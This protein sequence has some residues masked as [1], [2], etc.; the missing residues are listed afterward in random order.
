MKKSE[1]RQLIKEEIK[2]IMNTKD[3]SLPKK[4]EIQF[5]ERGSYN[6]ITVDGKMMKKKNG[7]F[8]IDVEE[9]EKY[10]KKIT[11]MKKIDLQNVSYSKLKELLD[12]ITENLKNKG[13]KFT[14]R[15]DM[16]VD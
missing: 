5:T 6:N 2:D 12:E 8:K 16:S 7:V 9:A 10:L 14:W 15:E 13:I 3:E 11:G 4:I 1:L